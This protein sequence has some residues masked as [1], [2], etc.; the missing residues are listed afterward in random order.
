[1]MPTFALE[2]LHERVK[3]T[4]EKCERNMQQAFEQMK[5]LFF[6]RMRPL[7]DRINAAEVQIKTNACVG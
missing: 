1:M 5:E 7:Q 6:N 2:L 3:A 4:C